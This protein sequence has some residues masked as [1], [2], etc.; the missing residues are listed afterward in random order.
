MG[1][2]R[3]SQTQKRRALAAFDGAERASSFEGSAL[4]AELDLSDG[5]SSVVVLQASDERGT[6]GWASFLPHVLAGQTAVYILRQQPGETLSELDQRVRQRIAHSDPETQRVLWVTSPDAPRST[7]AKLRPMLTGYCGRERDVLLVS[8]ANVMLMAPTREPDEVSPLA[9]NASMTHDVGVT[10]DADVTHDAGATRDSGT[11][12]LAGAP[13][14]AVPATGRVTNSTNGHQ[15]TV[16]TAAGQRPPSEPAPERATPER[17]E[18]RW[19]SPNSD[20]L[21]DPNKR[22]A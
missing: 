2:V 21:D 1:K 4:A 8:G 10:H 22:T 19:E 3:K 17:S 20:G 12:I 9:A 14:R 16:G 13:R 18:V 5:T 11:P 15:Q 6:A 7:I